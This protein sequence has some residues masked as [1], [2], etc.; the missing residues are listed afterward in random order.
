VESGSKQ[1]VYESIAI[2]PLIDGNIRFKCRVNVE[3]F[4]NYGKLL[5][6]IR[7]SRNSFI[8]VREVTSLGDTDI[9][10]EAG[11]MPTGCYISILATYASQ[12]TLGA[13]K[14]TVTGAEISTGAMQDPPV[15]L[16]ALPTVDGTTITDYAGQSAAVPSRFYAK[17]Q[18]G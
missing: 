15:P 17:Y 12:A 6:G 18:K 7:N 16:P 14:Y 13:Y 2:Y 8:F 10:F 5:V 1:T 11:E 3:K 4:S 9:I